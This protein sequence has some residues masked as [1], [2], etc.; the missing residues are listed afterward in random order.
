VQEAVS[1]LPVE[2]RVLYIFSDYTS[3]LLL[4]APEEASAVMVVLYRLVFL[5]V[6][7]VV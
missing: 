4:T 1:G 5:I 7:V 6:L 3:S 2:R